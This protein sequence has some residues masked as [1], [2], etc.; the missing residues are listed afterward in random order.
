[1]PEGAFWITN[2]AG[3]NKTVIAI[4]HRLS[5]IPARARQ[6]GGFLFE[7]H[8]SSDTL[9]ERDPCDAYGAVE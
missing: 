2:A 1:L 3:S 4:A 7:N 5:T 6:P 9:V 8:K